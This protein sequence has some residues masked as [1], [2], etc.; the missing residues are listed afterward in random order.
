[1]SLA[2]TM[3]EASSL[4]CLCLP[5]DQSARPPMQIV[6]PYPPNPIMGRP[7]ADPGEKRGSASDINTPETLDLNRPIREAAQFPNPKL[8]GSIAATQCRYRA[9]VT[10]VDRT[11]SER[12]MENR[13]GF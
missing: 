6:L 3:D 10:S 2:G 13:G 4:S 12:K 7:C 8:E 9:L 1:M 11:P 5:S